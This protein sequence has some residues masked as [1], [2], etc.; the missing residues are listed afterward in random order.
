[1]FLGFGLLPLLLLLL[2]LFFSHNVITIYTDHGLENQL[3]EYIKHNMNYY[4]FSS[5]NNQP[6]IIY[7]R[8]T[9]R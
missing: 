4:L 1:M 7:V 3:L 5:L 2:L 8:K 9:E 6:K